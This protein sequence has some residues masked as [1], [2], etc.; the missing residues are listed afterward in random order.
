MFLPMFSRTMMMFLPMFSRTV[1]EGPGA[2]RGAEI[3]KVAE[4]AENGVAV[5]AQH[6]ERAKGGEQRPAAP[7]PQP[8]AL[9][10]G[11]GVPFDTAHDQHRAEEIKTRCTTSAT[12]C[13][14]TGCR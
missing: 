13:P 7:H 8:A 11:V 6:T 9:P 14:S 10:L 12:C 1:A 2:E 5:E 4:S 3:E